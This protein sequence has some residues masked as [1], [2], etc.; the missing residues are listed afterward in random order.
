MNTFVFLL[1]SMAAAINFERVWYFKLER[2]I[3]YIQLEKRYLNPGVMFD[4]EKRD[5]RDM[6]KH[7]E[8]FDNWRLALFKTH[9]PYFLLLMLRKYTIVLNND[10]LICQFAPK[11]HIFQGRRSTGPHAAVKIG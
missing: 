2:R 1:I 5:F 9:F 7:Y 3:N 8:Y 10:K 4:Y 11:L 6:T